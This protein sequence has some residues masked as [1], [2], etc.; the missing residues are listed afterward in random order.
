[1]MSVADTV[2]FPM[3]DIL[4]LGT[5]SRMNRPG[6]DADNWRWRLKKDQI[7]PTVTQNL[8]DM[9]EVYGRTWITKKKCLPVEFP[10]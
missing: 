8:G 3:Q 1:M 7:S 2:L 6:T 9:T 5:Q 4:G 10:E